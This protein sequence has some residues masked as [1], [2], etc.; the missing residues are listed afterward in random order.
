MPMNDM[1]ALAAY[2]KF[3]KSVLVSAGA[4]SG[5]TQVLTSRVTDIIL[6]G[7][8]PL[9]LLVLTFT[10][11]AA[12]EMK[13]RVRGM[14]VEKNQLDV[15]SL[16]EQSYITTFDSFN[17]SICKKYAYALNISPQIGIADGD[18]MRKKKIDILNDILDELYR[19]KDEELFSYLDK[20]TEK[21]DT[22]L[23]T[24]LLELIDC[25]DKKEDSVTYLNQY[26]EIYFNKKFIEKLG[27]DYLTS[28]ETDF[29]ELYKLLVAVYNATT[30][31]ENQE[32]ISELM[33]LF[34][35]PTFQNYDKI[36]NENLP[37]TS[38]ND[39]EER[40]EL[41]ERYRKKRDEIKKDFYYNSLEELKTEYLMS[42]ETIDFL[43]KILIEYYKRMEVFMNEFNFYEFNDIQKMAIKLVREH[44][45]IR[46][47]LKYRFK[48]ILIDEYQDTSDL[49]EI[50]IS[51]FQNDNLFMVGDIKQSIY[52]FRNANPN[53]FKYKYETYYSI[54]KDIY[55]DL[56]ESFKTSP[57]YLIDM[58][59]NFRSRKE[60]LKDINN[61]FS[62]LMT[63]EVGDA[64]YRQS[65]LMQYGLTLYDDGECSDE[66][67]FESDFITYPYNSDLKLE[68]AYYEAYIVAQDILKKVG[69]YQ[70]FAKGQGFRK[71]T[72]NDFCIIL[73]RQK[74]MEVFS[75]V[76]EYY[77]IPTVIYA[78]KKISES[79]TTLL[80]VN[81]LKLV[82]LSYENKFDKNYFHAL[83]SILRSPLYELSDDEICE[84]VA[85]RNLDNDASQKAFRLA[86]NIN[87]ISNK[88]I[89]EEILFSFDFY[90]HI[91]KFGNV[92]ESLHE[93]EFLY[94]KIESLSDLAYTWPEIAT[95]L[96]ELFQSD[97]D[98]KYSLDTSGSNG[99]KMMNIH[100]S[101][102]LEFPICYF[103]DFSH[104][105]N[106]ADM[107]KQVRFDNEYGIYVPVYNDGIR[108]T[109]IKKLVMKRVLKETISERLR[110]F[111]VALTRAREKMIF[112]RN[113]A[114]E[115]EAIEPENH[116]KFGQY[117]DYIIQKAPKI[118]KNN[119]SLNETYFV[120]MFKAQYGIINQNLILPI[121]K[122]IEY[123]TINVD[124][125]LNIKSNASK[126]TYEIISDEIKA[127]L[128]VGT[129]YHSY[130]EMIDFKNSV[131][132]L[133]ALNLDK[134][135]TYVL[136]QMLENPLF[137]SIDKAKTFKEHEFIFQ[138]NKEVYH[139]IIDLLVEYDDH[140]DI[141]DYKLKNFDDEAYDKQLEVYYKYVKSKTDK[142]VNC[143]LVSI[144][145][146]NIRKVEIK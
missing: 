123:D 3:D 133:S 100:K 131:E 43:K 24:S 84:I 121:S 101:K 118:F 76:L 145:D 110:L 132:S 1:Q 140:Y 39:A 144:I 96:A 42:K 35:N 139:G 82:A 87:L 115:K 46:L 104:P 78:D 134:H 143:Y 126:K 7:T 117:F 81:L 9:N 65:H 38:K 32:K 36:L 80:L 21:K 37:R 55:P 109:F 137:K 105:F 45:D 26:D 49:Q 103:G 72:Y 141:I 58:N 63:S 120:P 33:T 95:Y 89:F 127:K 31:M 60:V 130:L 30:K 113:E 6:N 97:I 68:Q 10:N 142:M 75:Q 47:E 116:T 85:K 129:R 53:I 93:T 107:K 128:E 40:K 44:E 119:I 136:K 41:G 71:A 8:S 111:Y 14:L 18:T 146:N 20:F 94:N 102:G 54:N 108:P 25:L 2:G 99:V 73:D 112:I 5:K 52:R 114:D 70:V 92:N 17:L 23:I 4:G 86:K 13:E 124:K 50:F 83:T 98:V 34:D 88:E 15:V 90:K 64:N 27:N 16:L 28:M 61:M 59:Q 56:K 67:G 79:Y 22:N 57:G 19:N 125:T 48:E 62:M 106:K 138:D 77:K 11:A 66:L 74:N 135:A 69:K 29:H 91:I 12:A 51:Y 122:P